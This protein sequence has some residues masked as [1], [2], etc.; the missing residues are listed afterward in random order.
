ML[1]EKLPDDLLAHSIALNLIA[2][3]HSAQNRA[4]GKTGRRSP[5]IDSALDPGWHRNRAN[6]AMLPNEVDDAPSVVPLLD[7][8]ERQGSDLRTP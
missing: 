3:V 2:A 5:G 7:M 8:P 6:A 1:L 4:L